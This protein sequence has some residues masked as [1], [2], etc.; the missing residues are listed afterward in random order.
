LVEAA[1]QCLLQ[2]ERHPHPAET[3]GEGSLKKSRV[4]W[5]IKKGALKIL[6]FTS[7]NPLMPIVPVCTHE[8]AGL[9]FL[10]VTSSVQVTLKNFDSQ[11]MQRKNIL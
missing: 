9:F 3:A 11:S 10:L 6:I 7:I 8:C 2:K 4:G 5:D 1:Q